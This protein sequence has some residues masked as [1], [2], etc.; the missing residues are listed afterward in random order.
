MICS[1]AEFPYEC[2]KRRGKGKERGKLRTRT[3]FSKNEFV[4]SK[5]GKISAELAQINLTD[6]P[7]PKKRLEN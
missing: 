2:E 4:S 7:G 3:M 1:W 6:K 5:L